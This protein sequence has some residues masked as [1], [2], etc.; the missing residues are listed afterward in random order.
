MA[1]QITLLPKEGIGEVKSPS[2][3]LGPSSAE[4]AGGHCSLG[5]RG[6]VA[7]SALRCHR[8][9]SGNR[10]AGGLRNT[11]DSPLTRRR[12]PRGTTSARTIGR[13]PASPD[14]HSPARSQ[15]V[16]TCSDH[17]GGFA[18]RDSHNP[19][20]RRPIHPKKSCHPVKLPP[21]LRANAR[22]NTVAMW[23]NRTNVRSRRTTTERQPEHS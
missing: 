7:C 8:A 10:S 20:R 14:F 23:Y 13:R 6:S 9:T 17:A 18:P 5:C 3:Q 21:L 1:S 19:V 4:V 16:P 11:S 12:S 22:L 2:P 15:R